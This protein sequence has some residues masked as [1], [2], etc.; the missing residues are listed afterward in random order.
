MRTKIICLTVVALAAAGLLAYTAHAGWQEK[1]WEKQVWGV[2]LKQGVAMDLNRSN[3]RLLGSTVTWANY[4]LL[5][6]YARNVGGESC[7]GFPFIYWDN[8]KYLYVSNSVSVTGYSYYPAS[9]P[10]SPR[11]M[12]VRGW[13]HWWA[14]VIDQWHDMYLTERL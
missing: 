2:T 9:R 5:G 1:W 13:S 6:V 14:D 10:C 12:R 7:G 8:E 11:L 3:H 4:T